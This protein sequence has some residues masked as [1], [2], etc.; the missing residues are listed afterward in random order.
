M[1]KAI[2]E[3]NKPIYVTEP[4]LPPLNEFVKYLEQIWESKWLTNNGQFHKQLEQELCNYLGVEF[5]SL[6][7]NGTLALLNALQVLRIN[8][9]VITEGSTEKVDGIQVNVDT[10]GYHTNS[11]E[12]SK[13]ILKIGEDISKT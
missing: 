10:V 4:V 1:I 9:E 7:S 6:F 2:M 12:L 8:G 3:N 13:V 5:I 11:P